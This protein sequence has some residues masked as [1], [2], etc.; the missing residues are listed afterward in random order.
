MAVQETQGDAAEMRAAFA[1]LQA[2]HNQRLGSIIEIQRAVGATDLDVDAVMRVICMRTMA[3]THAEGAAIL[4]LDGDGFD[5]RVA[6]GFLEDAVGT[7]VPIVGSQPGWMHRHDESG[8]LGDAKTDPRAGRLARETGMRAGI[9]VQLRHRD[10]KIG[11]LIVVSRRPG[12]FTQSRCRA[13]TAPV[14]HALGRARARSRVRDPGPAGRSARALRDH[15]PER[16]DRH[17][18]RLTRRSLP[19]CESGVR[20]HVRL[21]GRGAQ[22]DDPAR[23]DPPR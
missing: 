15:L 5:L 22:R 21:P 3:L 13:V 23:S 7:R 6:T 17:H 8:L 10:E 4:I 9:A 11:Q 2:T 1:E 19:R 12:A 16:G 18:R 14:G 20:D